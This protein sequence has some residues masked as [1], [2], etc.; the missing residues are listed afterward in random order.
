MNF[1]KILSFSLLFLICFIYFN[2]FT[3]TEVTAYQSG[4]YYICDF[5]QF[6]DGDPWINESIDG[7]TW[8]QLRA[9]NLNTEIEVCDLGDGD[10]RWGIDDNDDGFD[11]HYRYWLY[12]YTNNITFVFSTKAMSS[13]CWNQ[14]KFFL[15]GETENDDDELMTL[16]YGKLSGEFFIDIDMGG[17]TT[18]WKNDGFLTNYVTVNILTVWTNES[19]HVQFTN[20]TGFTHHVWD[21]NPD[22]FGYLGYCYGRLYNN[23]VG[24]NCDLYFDNLTVESGEIGTLWDVDYPSYGSVLLDG[25]QTDYTLT[26]AT[27]IDYFDL[28]IDHS[29]FFE[30]QVKEIK[31]VALALDDATDINDIDWVNLKIN[32]IPIGNYD[33]YYPYDEKYILVWED[34]NQDISESFITCEFLV[35]KDSGESPVFSYISKDSDVDGD[36]DKKHKYT[37]N[38]ED[39]WNGFYD[40]EISENYDFLYQVWFELE[41]IVAEDYGDLK[42]YSSWGDI[43]GIYGEQCYAW[44][45]EGYPSIWDLWTRKNPPVQSW[46]NESSHSYEGLY[47]D[48]F[49]GRLRAFDWVISKDSYDQFIDAGGSEN[50]FANYFSLHIYSNQYQ[51]PQNHFSE[52]FGGA[53]YVIPFSS[54][55]VVLRWVFDTPIDCNNCVIGYALKWVRF[56]NIIPCIALADFDN[57][58]DGMIE[59]KTSTSSAM[60]NDYNYNGEYTVGYDLVTELYYEKKYYTEQVNFSDYIET[61]KNNYNQYETVKISGHSGNPSLINEL[62]AYHKDGTWSEYTGQGFPKEFTS[63]EIFFDFNPKQSGEWNVTIER[64]DIVYATAWFN[65]SAYDPNYGIISY[66]NPSFINDEVTI[67]AM[68]NYSDTY[69]V[70]L[71]CLASD[72]TYYIPVTTKQAWHVAGTIQFKAEGIYYI[73]MQRR[74]NSSYDWGTVFEKKHVCKARDYDNWIKIEYDTCN[75]QQDGLGIENCEQTI[76]Y[77]HNYLGSNNV[78]ILINT[79]ISIYDVGASSRGEVKFIPPHD[80]WYNVSLVYRHKDGSYQYL[81]ENQSFLVGEAGKPPP[82]YEDIQIRDV[83]DQVFTEEQQT[84]L[85]LGLLLFFLI[86]PA[87][88]CYRWKIRDMNSNVYILSTVVGFAID[89]YLGLFPFWVLVL[90]IFL[91]TALFVWKILDSGLVRSSTAYERERTL[92]RESREGQAK[93]RK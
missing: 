90:F 23:I 91:F 56:N 75:Y 55:W 42:N 85:G 25:D 2:V 33:I 84:L 74:Q 93:R 11:D 31:Q 7:E 4:D 87:Y 92:R 14:K 10:K 26:E 9:T 29:D 44:K 27:S 45:D 47:N 20:G 3:F 70:R 60:F 5:S 73:E 69:E 51:D 54:Q 35:T 18:Q 78:K 67:E 53:D 12:V 76:T 22:D 6:A 46:I 34:V 81:C 68:Y 58:E 38:N 13:S 49:S 15:T 40:G 82:S 65:V 52:S 16:R 19:Y 83:I 66:P 17:D 88:I 71:R 37:G 48:Y 77:Q 62:K 8:L 63:N 57:N 86:L 61:N 21:E 43:D 89:I 32:D 50:Q 72:Q 24:S 36:G 41:D 64:N 79:N 80:G 1:N 39:Y 59:Y 30:S 28:E